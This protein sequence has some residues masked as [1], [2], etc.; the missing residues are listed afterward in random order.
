MFKQTRSLSNASLRKGHHN[1]VHVIREQ[2]S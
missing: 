2:L 1:E